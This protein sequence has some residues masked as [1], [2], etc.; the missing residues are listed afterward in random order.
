MQFII[1][2]KFSQNRLCQ[3]LHLVKPHRGR[4][5]KQALTIG[6]AQIAKWLFVITAFFI[7]NYCNE[8]E[9]HGNVPLITFSLTV[10]FERRSKHRS[11]ENDPL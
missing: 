5:I 8:K 10:K 11:S 9:E 4:A 3:L 7:T 1:F 6:M 2:V